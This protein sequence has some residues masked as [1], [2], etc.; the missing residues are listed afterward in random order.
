[1][2]VFLLCMIQYSNLGR[3][4][5]PQDSHITRKVMVPSICCLVQGFSLLHFTSAFLSIYS[6]RW[7]PAP[8]ACICHPHLT[9]SGL[10]CTSAPQ[11]S[12]TS[13]L[14]ASDEDHSFPT[15]SP[16]R[17][18]IAYG[19]ASQIRFSTLDL[20]HHCDHHMLC[21]IMYCILDFDV[22]HV[23]LDTWYICSR[24]M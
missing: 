20:G 17:P 12:R 8:Q 6:S 3:S 19:P 9:A 11:R 2:F 21:M 22:T 24:L 23:H 15:S 4:L 13:A 1:M 14:P 5:T 7:P 16:V 10:G 18:F